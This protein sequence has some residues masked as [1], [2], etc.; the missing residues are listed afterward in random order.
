MTA[1]AESLWKTEILFRFSKTTLAM[2]LNSLP[3]H[4][5]CEVGFL[6]ASLTI[7]QMCHELGVGCS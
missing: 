6:E 1:V 3:G 5:S 4:T 7:N 2:L